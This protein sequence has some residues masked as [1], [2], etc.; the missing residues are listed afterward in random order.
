MRV[1][2]WKRFLAAAT[3]SLLGMVVQTPAALAD[4]NHQGNNQIDPVQVCLNGGADPIS[5]VCP[6]R[7]ACPATTF[8]V[9]IG[10]GGEDHDEGEWKEHVGSTLSMDFVSNG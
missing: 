5:C 3:F 6:T 4:D 2:R 9:D 7:N 1:K 8:T 10:S